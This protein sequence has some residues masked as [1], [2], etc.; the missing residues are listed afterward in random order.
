MRLSEPLRPWADPKICVHPN[1]VAL[2]KLS[3][4]DELLFRCLSCG[5]VMNEH[6]LGSRTP[7]KR[8]K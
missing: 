5:D 4:S 3:D 8:P 2:L 6:D 7:K 1:P